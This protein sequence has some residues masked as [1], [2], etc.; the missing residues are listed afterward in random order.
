MRALISLAAVA[1]ALVLADGADARTCRDLGPA[2][3]A[4]VNILAKH[5]TCRVARRVAKRVAKVP[6]YGGCTGAG[7][8]GL[9]LHEPCRRLGYR[10]HGAD[11]GL[12]IRVRCSRGLKR[13]RFDLGRA[14]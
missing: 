5:T 11:R 10:C 6:T 3:Y 12:G 7:R 8:N 2:G 13:I 14:S 9:F 1:A 4:P